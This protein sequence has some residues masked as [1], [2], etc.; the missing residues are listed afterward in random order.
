MPLERF[1]AGIDHEMAEIEAAGMAKGPEAVVTEFIRPRGDKGPRVRL[2][3]YSDREF[4]RMNSNSYLGLSI[5][6]E[7]IR[8]SEQGAVTYGVGPGAVRFVSGTYLPHVQLEKRLAAF[9]GREDGMLTSSAYTSVIGV[10]VTLTTPE[11]I[12]ISDELNHNCIINAVRLARPKERRVYRHL[13]MTDLEHLLRTSVGQCETVLIV[14]DGIFSMRGVYAPLDKI[15]E[16]ARSYEES[17]PKGIV[18]VVDDSHGVGALGATGRGTEEVTETHADVLIAT[19]GKA[20]GANGGYIVSSRNVIRYLRQKNQLYIYTNPITPAEAT[21]AL[22]AVDILDS[23]EGRRLLER[24]RSIKSRF[25]SGLVRLGYE[26]VLNPHPVTPLMVRD[27]E[28]TTQLVNFL[29]DHDILASG[30]N[31]PIVPKGDQLIRFQVCAD[32]TESD[33]DYVLGVLRKP[34]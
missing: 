10:I 5:R 26:T 11:T 34:W 4:L 22:A 23:A 18:V 20:I 30:I 1:A 19:M 29:R 9:H 13:N 27:T 28:K 21:A 7:V 15:M 8:A 31:Y 32:H 33:I 2:E 3:G 14:T 25:E 24:L 16:L 17:F 12:I 6:D